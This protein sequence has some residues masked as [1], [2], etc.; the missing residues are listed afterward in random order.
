MLIKNILLYN[1]DHIFIPASILVK[2]GV[3]EKIYQDDLFIPEE[4]VYD[5]KGQKA[6]P[7]LVD[8][9]FHGC[10]GVDF[11]DGSSDGLSKIARY[12][13]SVGVTNICPASMTLSAEELLH[14]M[15]VAGNYEDNSGSHFVGINMEGPFISKKNKGAQA[16]CNVISCD[17]SLFQKLQEKAKGKIKLV[18][19]APEEAGAM[20]FIEA[21]KDKVNVSIAHTVADYETSMEAFA[22]GANHVTHLCNAMPGLHHRNPGVIGA[23]FDSNA[24]VELICD[25]IHVHPSMIRIIFQMF[26]SDKICLISDSMRATGL[27]DGQYTLGGQDVY[28]K[29][30]LATLKDGT[31]AGSVTNLM[32]CLR[33]LVNKVGISLEDAVCCASENPARSIG[34]FDSCGSLAPGKNA[35]IVILND[36]LEVTDVFISGTLQ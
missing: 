23:A 18:D 11:C 8:I 2:N 10:V 17:L 35:D 31:I 20:E 29:G 16:E 1:T 28:V 26:G 12:Q 36:T 3:I 32:D 9:H 30:S 22:K 6:I 4:T 25:G 19:L 27:A 34:I 33:F 13:A 14:I 21:V 5:G 7:G 15:E 24:F